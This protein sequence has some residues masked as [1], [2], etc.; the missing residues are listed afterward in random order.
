M[1][2]NGMSFKFG[3][4]GYCLDVKELKQVKECCHE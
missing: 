4:I 3:Y 1:K 2:K